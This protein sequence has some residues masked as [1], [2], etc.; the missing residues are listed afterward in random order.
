MCIRDRIHTTQCRTNYR[1]SIG[2]HASLV[3][4]VQY[5]MQNAV[6]PQRNQRKKRHLHEFTLV[7][8]RCGGNPASVSLVTILSSLIIKKTSGLGRHTDAKEQMNTHDAMPY[9]L[10]SLHETPRQPCSRS[11]RCDARSNAPA[12]GPRKEAIPSI[13]RAHPRAMRW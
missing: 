8:K 3:R 12:T 13:I 6:H 10:P 11:A 4:A 1:A 5:A 9:Q 7:S 2:L